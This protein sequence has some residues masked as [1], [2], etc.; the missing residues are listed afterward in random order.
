M[1]L[2]EGATGVGKSALIQELR[3][4]AAAAGGWFVHGKFDQVQVAGNRG[5]APEALVREIRP[6]LPETAKVKTAEAQTQ[7][8]VDDVPRPDARRGDADEH[9]A[10]RRR[11]HRHVL[12]RDHLGRSEAVD[13]TRLHDDAR[14]PMRPSR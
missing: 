6:L 5:V 14:C 2:V 7:E 4:M 13:A 12:E 9:L 11:G 3:P 10:R 1:V 8:A